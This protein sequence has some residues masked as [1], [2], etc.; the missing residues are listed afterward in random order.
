MEKKT[1]EAKG[2]QREYNRVYRQQKEAAESAE[3]REARLAKQ[4]EAWEKRLLKRKV[5]K[6]SVRES[7]GN[8]NRLEKVPRKE[9]LA[10]Q[11]CKTKRSVARKDSR[12]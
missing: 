8:R 10:W 3:E 4:R 2:K 7:I 5:N 1:A 6:M 12:S 9:K 11:K